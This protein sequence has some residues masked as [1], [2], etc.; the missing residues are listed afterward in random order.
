[1]HIYL[2]DTNNIKSINCEC[3]RGSFKCS[4][5]A[6]LFIYSI[7]NLSRTDVEC[8]W[9]KKKPSNK[10][11]ESAVEMFPPFNEHY[12]C[13]S[14]MPT[15]EDRRYLYSHLG[16]YGRFTGLWWIMSPEP[17]PPQPLPVPKIEELIQCKE[18]LLLQDQQEQI[19]YIQDRVKI[20][21]DCIKEV[22]LQTKGQRDNPLWHE[23]RRGRLTASNFGSVLNAKRITPSL[24]KR[25]L[26]EYDLSVKS[27]YVNNWSPCRR[28]GC[29]AQ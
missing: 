17:A 4:H 19:A 26:G 22:A 12:I 16:E 27:C 3:P 8:S 10:T 24:T 18:F 2:D 25:L 13:L 9:R 14:R 21:Q 23:V 15:D 28:N 1:M 7:H 6:A 20:S 5:A 29:M 11:P